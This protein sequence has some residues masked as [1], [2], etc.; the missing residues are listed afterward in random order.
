M[1]WCNR[2]LCLPFDIDQDAIDL[3]FRLPQLNF[4]R[5][6][7]A[8]T[9]LT[10]KIKSMETVV[11]IY[12]IGGRVGGQNFVQ[13]AQGQIVTGPIYTDTTEMLNVLILCEYGIPSH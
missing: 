6:G 7:A 11:S 8:Y 13:D 4:N 12:A 10:R 1:W 2:N 5:S 3:N 9:V